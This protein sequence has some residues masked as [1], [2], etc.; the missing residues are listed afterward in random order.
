MIVWDFFSY[1][2]VTKTYIRSIY[3]SLYIF[4]DQFLSITIV[5][6]SNLSQH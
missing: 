1:K 4:L 2:T 3:F 6:Q 5:K